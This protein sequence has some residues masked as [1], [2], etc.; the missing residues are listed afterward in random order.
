MAL[1]PEPLEIEPGGTAG[2]KK[3]QPRVEAG[4]LWQRADSMSIRSP[5]MVADKAKFMV[6]RLGGQVF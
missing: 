6:A 5:V 2:T 3:R 4:Q 1:P